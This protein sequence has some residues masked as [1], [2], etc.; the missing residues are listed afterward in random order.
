MPRKGEV[1]RREILPDPKYHDRLVTKF[2]NNMMLRGKKSLVEGIFYGA[3]DL[4]GERTK[5]DPLEMFKRALDNVK[6]VVEVRSRRVGGATY[7]VPIEVRQSRRVALGMRWIVQSARARH[8]KSMAERLAG[9]LIEAA[10]NRGNAVKKKEDTHR[11]A[12]ANN[13]FSHYRW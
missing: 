10:T 2:M 4:V 7:Q 3:L 5:E 11:M 9:E 13:A 12:E 8:E 1:R 6:P